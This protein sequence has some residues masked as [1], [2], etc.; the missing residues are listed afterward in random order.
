MKRV[1]VRDE[2]VAGVNDE[3]APDYRAVRAGGQGS[4]ADAAAKFQAAAKTAQINAK[5]DEVIDLLKKRQKRKA[6]RDTALWGQME[7]RRNMPVAA[8]PGVLSPYEML[9]QY[10]NANVAMMAQK[11]AEMKAAYDARNPHKQKEATA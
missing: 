10:N 7:A 6:A 2:I 3:C 11:C 8:V 4:T 5:L 1:F 9:Q